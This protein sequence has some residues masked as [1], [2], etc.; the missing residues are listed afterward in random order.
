MLCKRGFD[1]KIPLQL[2][3]AKLLIDEQRFQSL[4]V[5]GASEV[6]VELAL[7]VNES[8]CG[9]RVLVLDCQLLDLQ[10]F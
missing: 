10:L 1:V 2:T 4:V 8:N 9:I 6:Q 7:I 5:E 3:F